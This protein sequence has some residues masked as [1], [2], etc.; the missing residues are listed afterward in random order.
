MWYLIAGLLGFQFT[1]D[2]TVF[3]LVFRVG[4]LSHKEQ[5]QK[6]SK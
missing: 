6:E 1:I 4:Y 2:V 3:W 5:T